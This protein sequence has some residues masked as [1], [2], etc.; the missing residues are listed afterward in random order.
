MKKAV[1]PV[2]K[3]QAQ[4]P[5]QDRVRGKTSREPVQILSQ[6]VSVLTSFLDQY[7]RS[8]MWPTADNDGTDLDRPLSPNIR[9]FS[10]RQNQPENWVGP[11]LDDLCQNGLLIHAVE[12]SATTREVVMAHRR[13]NRIFASAYEDALLKASEKLERVARDR[14]IEYSDPLMMF[15][16]R[17]TNPDKFGDRISI[18]TESEVR[19]RVTELASKFGLDPGELIDLAQEIMENWDPIQHAEDV[20]PAS[21]S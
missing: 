4:V 15:L 7:P 10:K 5:I 11:F 1:L 3:A 9:R 8:I 20:T 21:E 14:A 2:G 18:R 6:E 17:G 16:L 13:Q 12:F 19:S